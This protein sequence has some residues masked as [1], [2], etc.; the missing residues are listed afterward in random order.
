MCMYVGIFV[1]MYDLNVYVYVNAAKW[2]CVLDFDG[3]LNEK[4]LE[5]Q[6]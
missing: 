2:T 1:Y 5:R 6:R 4:T 3:V